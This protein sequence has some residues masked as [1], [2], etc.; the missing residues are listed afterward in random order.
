MNSINN[1]FISS[2]F[3]TEKIG[4][5]AGIKTLEIMQKKKSWEKI[6]KLGLYVKKEWNKL[7]LNYGFKCSISGISALPKFN[8]INK[9]NLKYRTFITQ[10]F[11]KKDF[12]NKPDLSEYFT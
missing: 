10:E 6:S 11:L 4:Y 9:D 7:F 12:S 8:F 3:W 2:T 1:S 5:A